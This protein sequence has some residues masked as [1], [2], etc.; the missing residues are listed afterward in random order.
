MS[1]NYFLILLSMVLLLGL[2]GAAAADSVTESA[3]TNVFFD[4]YDSIKKRL[5]DLVP[6]RFTPEPALSRFAPVYGDTIYVNGELFVHIGDG[7]QRGDAYGTLVTWSLDAQYIL[8]E[9]VDLALYAFAPIGQPDRFIGPGETDINGVQKKP[10]GGFTGTF[11][12]Q[13]HTISNLTI[14]YNM[15]YLGLFRYIDNATI[16]N[17]ILEGVLINAPSSMYVGSLIGLSVGEYTLVENCHV[18]GTV[19][20]RYYLGGFVGSVWDFGTV[21]SSS[22]SV[23]VSGQE[24]GGFVGYSYGGSFEDCFATGNA[25][26]TSSFSNSGGFAAITDGIIAVNCSASGNVRGL[27]AAGGFIGYIYNTE[28][29]E[30]SFV[31]CSATGNVEGSE[32]VGGFVGYFIHY[33]GL[34]VVITSSSASGN[35]NGSRYIGGFIGV[36]ENIN[37]YNVVFEDCVAEGNVNGSS[38]V[39]GFIGYYTNNGEDSGI[40]FDAC[41]ASGNVNGSDSVGGFIGLLYDPSI[42]SSIFFNEC[43][44]AGTVNGSLYVGGFIGR[45]L[46]DAEDSN[47]FFNT[48]SASG[49]VTGYRSVGGFLGSF[50]GQNSGES[51]TIVFDSCSAS[52]MIQGDQYIGGFVGYFD[53]PGENF[54]IIFE[55]CAAT[56]GVDGTYD[57]GGFAG[58]S[59]FGIFST[60]SAAGAVT[61]FGPLGGFIGYS[62]S[63]QFFNC[64][65]IGDVTASVD[66]YEDMTFSTGGFVGISGYSVFEKCT[67]DGNV[68]GYSMIGGFA[69]QS[70]HDE[71]TVC[72]ASGNVGLNSFIIESQEYI[73]HSGGFAGS[74][75]NTV[76]SICSATGDVTG[77]LNVGGFAGSIYSDDSGIF[78]TEAW[79]TNCYATGNVTGVDFVGGF[80]GSIEGDVSVGPF[81]KY[82]YAAGDVTGT[83]SDVGCFAGVTMAGAGDS[84]IEYSF[85]KEGNGGVNNGYAMPMPNDD[86]MKVNTFLN[87]PKNQTNGTISAWDITN[88]PNSTHIWYVHENEDYP[89]F[90]LTYGFFFVTYDGNNADSGTAPIDSNEYL[91][92]DI[93]TVLGNTNLV[94]NGFTFD[95]W[96]YN[97][98]TYRAGNVVIMFENVTMRAIWA[99]PGGGGG[100]NG[101]GNGTVV[102]PGGN[103]STGNN[104]TGNNSTGNNSTE[105]PTDP[106]EPG[107][108]VATII[109]FFVIAIAVFCYRR[110][111]EA[112]EEKSS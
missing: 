56:G 74:F 52:G 82:T 45:Y 106:D 37:G 17:V 95:G 7:G 1:K 86:L 92:G 9:D 67:A 25:I 24:P 48:C 63:S 23:N 53:N 112:K 76:V 44:A 89:R 38:Y 104:S 62:F 91:Y 80:V 41:S 69:G 14:N 70:T 35:V 61:G 96:E 34:D 59:T 64:S 71:M 42:N 10:D 13:N 65:A 47:V 2:C 40:S 110:Y 100:G 20:G 46:N 26:G 78:I 77:V 79:I 51:C 88:S 15:H 60:C 6:D 72:F 28:G 97:G 8:I 57:V 19:A 84:I 5:S 107:R 21:Q 11:D 85:Y 109:L 33:E 90:V 93:A 39:G 31:D 12:G 103:N 22:S 111:E 108:E 75:S 4:L 94:K 49:N 87:A 68:I 83:G 27:D 32:S 50:E 36:I 81:V 101:T 102:P 30:I 105:P 58:N 54:N 18:S 43:I 66:I 99:P 3:S 29:F 73:S 55:K 16:Q 98:D